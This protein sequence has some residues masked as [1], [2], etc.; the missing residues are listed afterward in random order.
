MRFVSIKCQNYR[1]YKS[2]CLEFSKTT[3]CD[4]HIVIAS[5][6]VGKTNFLNA[7]NWCLYGDE[8]HLSN[9]AAQDGSSANRLP[10][11]NIEAADDAKSE[12]KPEFNVAVTVTLEDAG[13]I[14]EIARELKFKTATKIQMGRDLFTCK[15]TKA[16]GSTDFIEGFAISEIIERFLPKGIREYFYFDGE[17]LLYYFDESKKKNIAESVEVIAQIGLINNVSGHLDKVLKE[18]SSLIKANSPD[19]EAKEREYNAIKTERENKEKEIIELEEQIK[20][21]E[22]VIAESDEIINGKEFLADK[23]RQYEKN[24]KILET[25]AEEKGKLDHQLV[26]IVKRYA[27]LVFLYGVNKD[28]AA[29]IAARKESGSL[30]P[31]FSEDDINES[32]DSCQC[33]LCGGEL[34]TLQVSKLRTLL[35]KMKSNMSAQLINDISKDVARAT[36]ISGY[37]TEKQAKLDEIQ[38]KTE[39]IETLQEATDELW[40]SISQYGKDSLQAVSDA[41]EQKKKN[42]ELRDL[43]REKKGEYKQHVET[44]KS[45]ERDAKAAFDEAIEKSKV[46]RNISNCYNF[47]KE[48]QALVDSISYEL[49]EKV[50]QDI[51]GLTASIFGELV[52]KKDTY[53]NV[54]LDDNY[55]LKLYH[56]RTGESCLDTC[57]AAEVELLALAFTLA[58]HKVSGYDSFLF[59]DTPVGRVSD[60]NRTN[61]AEV[62]LNVSTE[63]Q[64]ILAFTPSEFSNEVSEVFKEDMVSSMTRLEMVDGITRVR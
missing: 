34:D 52:W 13:V 12:G 18:Y 31:S 15:L 19:V 41:I 1:Q 48:A 6:G 32:I 11:Y 49:A 53:G 5:N 42:I 21:A 57:S 26:E 60:F 45:N 63:K 59:I 16:D 7:T 29:Y 39:Q 55:N 35:L 36:E 38:S 50:R 40:R 9:K 30:Y 24:K 2:L 62:L 33:K 44:L 14:Y 61:F 23:N 64:I 25:L 4:M 28:V 8:P 56:S 37:M 20:E 22:K 54:E 58:V 43:N 3:D 51:A 10:I 47:A 17:Q 46:S 27:V